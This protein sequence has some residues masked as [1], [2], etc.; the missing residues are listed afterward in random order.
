[1]VIVLAQA[2]LLLE[3]LI[4]STSIDINWTY[5]IYSACE[6]VDSSTIGKLLLLV[7]RLAHVA[8]A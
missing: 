8:Y 6:V 3:D 1:M 4:P 2:A 7:L 5:L